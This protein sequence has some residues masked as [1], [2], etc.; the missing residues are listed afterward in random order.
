[1][2]RACSRRWSP[3]TCLNGRSFEH[4][5]LLPGDCLEI[6]PIVLELLEPT[7]KDPRREPTW[8]LGEAVEANTP[9]AET[10]TQSDSATAESA[11][12]PSPTSGPDSANRGGP[13]RGVSGTSWICAARNSPAN[14]RKHIK[15]GHELQA[16]LDQIRQEASQKQA[17]YLAGHA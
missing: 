11:D 4:S 9:C 1:M 6:G 13:S 7:P 12:Q 2:R 5:R 14:W 15:L 3:D 16:S 8:P 10:A 17:G